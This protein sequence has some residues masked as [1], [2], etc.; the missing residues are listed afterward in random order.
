MCH[1]LTLIINIFIYIFIYT[2]IMF[3]ILIGVK[4]YRLCDT[5]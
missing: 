2:L 1:I 3:D 5:V 4:N